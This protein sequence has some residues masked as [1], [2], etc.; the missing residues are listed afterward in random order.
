MPYGGNA[1]GTQCYGGGELESIS[2]ITVGQQSMSL[3]VQP[4][5]NQPVP[6]QYTIPE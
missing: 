4:V 2:A 1:Y 6:P 5:I 3:V